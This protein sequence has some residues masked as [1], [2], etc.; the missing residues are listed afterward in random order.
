MTTLTQAK[1]SP[2]LARAIVQR[3]RGQTHGPVTRLMSPSDLGEILKP[4]VF[5][6]LFDHEGAPF[7]APL[8]P[9]SGIATL[10]YVA[11]GAVSYIDPDNIR[12]TLP[13]GG[14]EWMQAG[15]GIGHGGGPA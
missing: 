4:F 6:D 13:A 10:T 9:H 12:G 8:H 1:S 2:R 11:G 7:D 3:T 15:R 14:V 5:L